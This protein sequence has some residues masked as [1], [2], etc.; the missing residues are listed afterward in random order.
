MALVFVRDP[1]KHGRK[2]QLGNLDELMAQ[3]RY[4]QVEATSCSS[5]QVQGQISM[6]SNRFSDMQ[7][8]LEEQ[9]WVEGEAL[10]QE[11]HE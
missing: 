10:E 5:M 3:G 1:H 4:L 6:R 11:P 2:V 8:H 9:V 7:N